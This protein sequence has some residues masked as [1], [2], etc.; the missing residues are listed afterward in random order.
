MWVYKFARS[1]KFQAETLQIMKGKL[2]NQHQANLFQPT[3]A[4]VVNPAH[5]LVKLAGKIDQRFL[6][7]LQ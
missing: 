6:N 2:L 4:Q 7:Y 1:R 5:E 3:L